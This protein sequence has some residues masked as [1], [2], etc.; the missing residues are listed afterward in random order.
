MASIKDTFG[1]IVGIVFL[2]GGELLRKSCLMAKSSNFE[3]KVITSL[4]QSI[5]V[6]QN[7]SLLDFL[8]RNSIKYCLAEAITSDEVR[9]FLFD[10]ED[11]IFLSLG[12]AWIFKPHEIES[13]FRGRLFNLHGSRLPQ[14]RGGGGFSWQILM[15]NKFG[16]CLLHRIDGKIDE[17]EIVALDEFLY[18]ANFRKPIEYENLYIKKNLE[19]LTNFLAKYRTTN[20]FIPVMQS[21]YFSTYWPRLSTE[22]NGW[23]NWSLDPTD[24]EKF[25]CAF[26]EPYCGAQTLLN[27]KKVMI[28]DVCLSPQD[29]VFHPYQTGIIYR[30]AR[31]WICVAIKGSTLV[32]EKLYDENGDDILGLVNVGD[33]FLTPFSYLE[34][35]FARPLYGPRGLK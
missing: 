14:N 13:V 16:F 31:S 20:T 19:F 1:P 5:E 10:T 15:G 32:I 23:I 25:I 8:K 11:F 30:K 35:S 18:P 33:R 34:S 12:A 7:E 26:D 17:G 22:V 29:G 28:K 2:G 3:I 21:E 9:Q 6:S 27:G 4:R 24:L